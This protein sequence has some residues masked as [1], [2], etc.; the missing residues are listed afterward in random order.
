MTDSRRLKSSYSRKLPAIC[1]A[2]MAS[3]CVVCS[4]AQAHKVN[5]F[6]Y[7]EGNRVVVEGYFSASVKAQDTTV[8]IYDESGKKIHEGR[9]DKNGIYTFKLA[10]IEPF[11]GDLKI[12]LD[13]AEGHKANYTLSATELPKAVQNDRAPKEQSSQAK[14]EVTPSTTLG[15]TSQ[16]LDR[17]ALAAALEKA[18][19]KKL[20]PVIRM[21]GRQEK[22]LLEQQRGEPKLAEIVGGIGWIVG[23]TGLTAFFWGRRRYG[24]RTSD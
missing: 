16:T 20:E 11:S 14:S 7:L 6:A 19:D 12:V 1:M 4:Q 21:L 10:D 18:M 3:I 22:L 13:V 17:D 24:K 5:V 9:T 15:V 2:A 23:L 8:S